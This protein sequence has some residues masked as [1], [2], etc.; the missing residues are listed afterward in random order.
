MTGGRARA[1]R[2]DE[3]VPCTPADRGQASPGP[4]A[5]FHALSGEILYV[6]VAGT[7]WNGIL[8]LD[9]HNI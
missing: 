5:P 1:G 8:T 9:W 6:I 7:L 3:R 2:A 4:V